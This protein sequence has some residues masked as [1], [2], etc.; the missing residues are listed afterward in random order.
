LSH[1][2][3]A[4][5]IGAHASW[6]NTEDPSARTAPGRAA[7]LAR[8]EDEVDP[9]RVLPEAERLRRAESA[10]KAYFARLALKSAKVRR[11]RKGA[12]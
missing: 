12:A 6:A 8:F 11:Q 3:A 10:R 5:R 9:D 4:G 7:F 1:H 2:A